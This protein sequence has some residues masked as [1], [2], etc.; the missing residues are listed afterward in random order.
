M[1][2]SHIILLVVIAVAI[3]VIF[4]SLSNASTYANFKDAFDK[5]GKKYTVVG[6]LDHSQQIISEP[7]RTTF[8]L[9]DK[10]NNVRKVIYNE[11]KP[12]DFERSESVV[13]T[14]YAEGDSFYASEISLKCP[15]KYNDLNKTG[16]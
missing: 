4:A 15:S 5:P 2:K 11:A 7:M 3:A 6:W 13:V 12:Q 10:E 9:K 8:Y 14:G 1:K 16:K